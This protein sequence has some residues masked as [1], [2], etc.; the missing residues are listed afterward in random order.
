MGFLRWLRDR[1]TAATGVEQRHQPAVPWAQS[2]PAFAV[3]DVETTGLSPRRDRILELAIVRMTLDGA[4]VD[5]WTQRFNPEGPVGATHIHGITQSD[6]DGQPRFSDLAPTVISRL[7]G[8]PVVGHNVAFDLGFLRAELRSAGWDAPELASYCTLEAS[9]AY[10]PSLTRRKLI[11][12]CCEAGV[13]LENAHSALGDARATAA[14]LRSYLRAAKGLDGR[15]AAVISSASGTEWPS[16]PTLPVVGYPARQPAAHRWARTRPSSALLAR[17]LAHLSTTEILEDGA[18]PE[19]GPYLELLLKALEDSLLSS[20]EVAALAELQRTY[21]LDEAQVAQS[22]DALL[23][24]LAHRALDDGHVSREERQEL[25][26]IASLL[27]VREVMITSLIERADQARNARLSAG[28]G[29]LPVGWELGEP[30]RV[31]DRVAFTGCDESE[32]NRLERRAEELGVRVIGSVS[33]L[34]KVLVTDESFSGR[35]SA[36]ARE[37]GTRRVHP[38]TFAVLLEHVQPAQTAG[39]TGEKP[40]RTR[41]EG[42][43]AGALRVPV[44]A[45]P[46]S[47]GQ[48]PS[49]AAIRAWA[50]ANGHSVGSRGRLPASVSEAYWQAHQY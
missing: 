19:T 1:T 45:T 6:V 48:E 33:R 11:D 43:F 49:T 20:V 26:S 21:G 5:E 24:V 3:I 18:P 2:P 41:P 35:K 39:S 36:R 42:I 28:L 14:L 22:H 34:T 25:K 47:H 37:L 44:S 40:S 29:P 15:M 16:A 46:H 17:Q 10:L 50:M 7:R 32:R 23:L 9:H 27:G 31:G 13:A 4:I 38:T 12:C 8:I 30:V